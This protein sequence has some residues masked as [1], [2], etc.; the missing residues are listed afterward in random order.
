[1]VGSGSLFIVV[2]AA[3]CLEGRGTQYVGWG[4]L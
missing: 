2:R 1:M 3:L 4:L